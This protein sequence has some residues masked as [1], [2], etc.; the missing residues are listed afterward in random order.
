MKKYLDKLFKL[1]KFDKKY[2]FFCI[3]IIII[4][5]FFGAIF[6]VLLN[7]SDK[8]IIIE[9]IQ[10][11][12]LSIK[13]NNFDYLETFKNTIIINFI[14]ILIII[15]LG[16]TCILSSINVLILFYKSFVIGFSIS[17]FLLAYKIKGLLISIVYIFPHLV[18]NLII[19]AILTS[20]TV[21]I[22]INLIKNTF[23][24]KKNNLNLY[25]QKYNLIVILFII[26]ILIT[27]V[28][29]SFVMPY[30]LKKLILFL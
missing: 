2:V 23:K 28:Y 12:I 14:T 3:T 17:G 30:I 20:F 25:F 1:I 15:I 26:L 13:N 18:L 6:T 29:E 7:K 24:K 16:I 11:F 27:S 19:L 22:S 10:K 4:G 8:N 5:V 21:K 9:Y